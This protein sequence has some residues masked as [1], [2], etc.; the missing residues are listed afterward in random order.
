MGAMVG[1][2]SINLTRKL[3]AVKDVDGR[4]YVSEIS[5]LTIERKNKE[6]DEHDRRRMGDSR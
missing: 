5:V 2:G 3:L 6:V 1:L 4:L